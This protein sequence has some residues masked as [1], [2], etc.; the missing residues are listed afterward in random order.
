MFCLHNGS[1]WVSEKWNIPPVSNSLPQ[2]F[3][4]KSP[5]QDASQPIDNQHELS[6]NTNCV[7]LTTLDDEKKGSLNI[8]EVLPHIPDEHYASSI[9]SNQTVSEFTQRSQS[10]KKLYILQKEDVIYTV[11]HPHRNSKRVEVSPQGFEKL[12]KFLFSQIN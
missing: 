1:V 5:H 9:L 11:E 7:N 10:N 8:N 2:S 12:K 6:P 4:K 3:Q